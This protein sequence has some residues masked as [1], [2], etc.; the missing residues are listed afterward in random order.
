MII[1]HC[2]AN[3]HRIVHSKKFYES[4]KYIYIYSSMLHYWVNEH[5]TV[6][7]K[8]FDKSVCLHDSVHKKYM[9]KEKTTKDYHQTNQEFGI[10]AFHT[11]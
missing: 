5:A 1:F 11:Q 6:C 8:Q 9:K 4:V 3:E 2:W 7:S 10:P